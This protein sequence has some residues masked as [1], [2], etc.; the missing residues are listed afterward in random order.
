MCGKEEGFLSL[1]DAVH[2]HSSNL[3]RPAHEE[4]SI[5]FGFAVAGAVS[6]QSL[7]RTTKTARQ[8]AA[9]ADSKPSGKPSGKPMCNSFPSGAGTQIE[10]IRCELQCGVG[11]KCALD[12]EVLFRCAVGYFEASHS[13]D[14]SRE[15]RGK[16]NSVWVVACRIEARARGRSGGAGRPAGVYL[17]RALP[18]N[19]AGQ[20][21]QQR[22]LSGIM[23]VMPGYG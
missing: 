9:A 16:E 3:S 13:W 19:N 17:L 7:D 11:A 21:H 5:G 2:P 20:T 22:G 14:K 1:V 12:K 18:A 6:F 8:S 23:K 10:S 4:N 15:T